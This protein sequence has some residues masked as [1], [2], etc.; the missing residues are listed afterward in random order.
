MFAVGGDSHSPTGGAFGA[1]M[2][3]VGATGMA[4]VLA[5]GEIR[6]EVP[7]TVRIDRSGRLADG[8]L[9]KD[10]M[11]AL[12]ARFGMSGGRYR[13]VEFAGRAVR[14]LPMQ[15]RM[16]LCNMAAELGAQAGLIA[17]SSPPTR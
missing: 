12:C 4:G 16:T 11:L 9:A 1:S 15:E 2:F 3:G 10:M 13:A 6:L 7:E 14:A 8:V 17:A 5:T